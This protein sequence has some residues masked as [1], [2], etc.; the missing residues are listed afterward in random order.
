VFWRDERGTTA[1]EY[2][3]MGALIAGAIISAVVVL[4]GKTEDTYTKS[5]TAIAAAI[6]G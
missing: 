2:A 1:V 6:G 3:L 4:G 5:S